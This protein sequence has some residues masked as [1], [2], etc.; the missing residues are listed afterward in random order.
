MHAQSEECFAY[1]KKCRAYETALGMSNLEQM[2]DNLSYMK[3]FKPLNEKERAA[4]AQVCNIFGN[5]G[6]IPCTAL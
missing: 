4:V 2:Q 1:F 3:D 6:A 5:L